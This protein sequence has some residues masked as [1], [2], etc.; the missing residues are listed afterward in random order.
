ML[1]PT[2]TS[3]SSQAN[4]KRGAPTKTASESENS[5]NE[6][7][8]PVSSHLGQA[9]ELRPIIS[10][11]RAGDRTVADLAAFVDQ[12]VYKSPLRRPGGSKIA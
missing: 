2:L 7:L 8:N 3:T 4:I 12:Q 5:P 1:L 11:W 6:V 10:H 9:D